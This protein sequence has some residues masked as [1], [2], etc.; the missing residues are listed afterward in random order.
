MT[1][2]FIKTRL[3]PCGIHCGKC[4][5]FADGPIK[6]H[7]IELQKALGNF[8]IYAKRFVDLLNEPR[9]EHY[10]AF[11]DLLNYFTQVGCRGCR[12]DGC[13]LFKNCQVKS[14]AA[15]NKIDYC[16]QCNDFPCDH[17]GFDENLKQR[18]ISI[19][20]KMKETSVES[21]YELIKDKPR[22]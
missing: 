1:Y 20:Q 4:F 15:N 18:W 2:D 5:A 14:C 12:L 21:Y 9:F 6:Q 16:F 13:I 22:Y 17:S 11:K 8:D 10:D 3:G 19:N 7:S